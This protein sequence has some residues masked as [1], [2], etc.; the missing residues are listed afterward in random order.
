MHSIEHRKQEKTKEVEVEKKARSA[1][2]WAHRTREK[3]RHPHDKQ[4]NHNKIV[5][6]SPCM[7]NN[8]P[9]II[10]IIMSAKESKTFYKNSTMYKPDSLGISGTV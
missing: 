4:T 8:L 9:T 6:N 3:E 10:I 2:G 7:D 5:N 1:K